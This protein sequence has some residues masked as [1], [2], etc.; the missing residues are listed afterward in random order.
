MVSRFVFPTDAGVSWKDE[1]SF[2]MD[3]VAADGRFGR[4][5]LRTRLRSGL[6]GEDAMP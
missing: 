1:V 6:C 4:G 3:G 5:M 2:R